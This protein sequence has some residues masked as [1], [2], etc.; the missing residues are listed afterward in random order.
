MNVIALRCS[1]VSIIKCEAYGDWEARYSVVFQIGSFAKYVYM[2]I[3]VLY[4]LFWLLFVCCFVQKKKRRSRDESRHREKGRTDEISV[5]SLLS[6]YLWW[7][8]SKEGQLSYPNF[9]R[10]LLLVDMQP[11]V[12]CFEI[13]GVLCCTI[14]EVPRRVIN[15]KEAGLRDPWN[16]V[17]WRK[18]KRGV[19]AQ[20]VS[21]HN[22]FES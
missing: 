2:C 18:S 16:S 1:C 5:L 10:G 21:F 4:S 15:Q 14:N 7:E 19:F 6:S 22:F 3:C 12:S 11:L 20:L 9:V 8:V 17:M 13:L